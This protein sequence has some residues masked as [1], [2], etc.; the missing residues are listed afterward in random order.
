MSHQDNSVFVDTSGRRGRVMRW[1]AAGVGIVCV[2]FLGIVVAGMFG[3]GPTGGPLPWTDDDQRDAPA[4][5]QPDPEATRSPDA[6]KHPGTARPEGTGDPSATASA[7]SSASSTPS[8]SATSSAPAAS[9]P[10]ATT[11]PAPT[12]TA[13][14]GKDTGPGK[15]DDA[16]GATKRPR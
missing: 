1:G 15:S 13:D 3:A 10:P 14:D 11:E 12:A 8:P 6:P 4:L 16:P 7:S 9:A 2:G 5:I